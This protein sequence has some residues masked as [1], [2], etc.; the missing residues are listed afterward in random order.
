MDDIKLPIHFNPMPVG[1]VLKH[2]QTLMDR[3]VLSDEWTDL[4][5]RASELLKE[6]TEDA[7]K[8]ASEG[9]MPMAY[10]IGGH[11]SNCEKDM[12]AYIEDWTWKQCS[13]PY[14]PLCGAKMLEEKDG[15]GDV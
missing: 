2:L 11:C 15:D 10:W 14:C 6:K 3:R 12:P 13:T 7:V 8:K 1:E 5:D 4:I 9:V